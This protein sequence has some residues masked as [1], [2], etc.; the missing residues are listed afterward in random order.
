MGHLK[1]KKFKVLYIDSLIDKLKTKFGQKAE[2]WYFYV[3]NKVKFKCFDRKH[4]SAHGQCN[5]LDR[6]AFQ[7][8]G[9]GTL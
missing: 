3:I 9:G 7:L 1:R 5:S 2:I 8:V 6:H 4:K